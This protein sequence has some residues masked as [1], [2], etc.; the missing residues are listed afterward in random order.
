[1]PSKKSVKVSFVTSGTE[2]LRKK[3]DDFLF[4][5]IYNLGIELWRTSNHDSKSDN[6]FTCCLKP[7]KHGFLFKNREMV[8]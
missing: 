5:P 8:S 4:L 7:S 3:V 1:M 6:K 2:K